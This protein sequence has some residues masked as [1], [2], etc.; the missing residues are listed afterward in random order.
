[1]FTRRVMTRPRPRPL[2]CMVGWWRMVLNSRW[3]VEP[4]STHKMQIFIEEWEC[5]Q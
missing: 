1:M 5:C 4:F 3:R 2:P